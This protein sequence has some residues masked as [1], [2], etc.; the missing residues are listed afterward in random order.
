MAT[1]SLI[2][3]MSL[4]LII[5]GGLLFQHCPLPLH[6]PPEVSYKKRSFTTGIRGEA[7][8]HYGGCVCSTYS[9]GA[10]YHLS[11]RDFLSKEWGK[12]PVEYE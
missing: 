4:R 3:L 9:S 1:P 8:Q 6:Q 10:I 5:P 2:R 12:A 11:K 7:K